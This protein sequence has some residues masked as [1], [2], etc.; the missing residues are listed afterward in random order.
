M[1]AEIGAFVHIGNNVVIGRSV[2]IK[3]CVQVLPNTVVPHDA[4]IPPFSIVGGN[5]GM[6]FYY[7]VFFIYWIIKQ[8]FSGDSVRLFRT[9]VIGRKFG[10]LKLNNFTFCRSIA[11][12]YYI[13]SY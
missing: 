6:L 13:L 1:A 12:N 2:I 10:N 7:S 5:P 4:V 11:E 3:S 8:L 9:R